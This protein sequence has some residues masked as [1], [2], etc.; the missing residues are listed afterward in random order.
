[1]DSRS[2]TRL[3]NREELD[4]IV[5]EVTAFPDSFMADIASSLW[6][7]VTELERVD[8]AELLELEAPTLAAMEC[9]SWPTWWSG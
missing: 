1:M 5:A 8:V 7:P 4:R 2:E 3:P 6:E 9:R